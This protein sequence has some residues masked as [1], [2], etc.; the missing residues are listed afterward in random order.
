MYC[1]KC[2]AENP[3][4]NFCFKCAAPVVK[5]LDAIFYDRQEV[6]FG[7][8][9]D[10]ETLDEIKYY[11]WLAVRYP[12]NQKNKA[13]KNSAKAFVLILASIFSSVS[14]ISFLLKTFFFN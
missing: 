11:K 9:F 1:L 8:V 7:E 6:L 2:A 14:L 5:N 3:F 12:I 4:A 10:A 13:E